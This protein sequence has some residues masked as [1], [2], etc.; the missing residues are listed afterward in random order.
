LRTKERFLG[1]FGKSPHFLF[2]GH[3]NIIKTQVSSTPK[4]FARA[5]SE[6]SIVLLRKTSGF[7]NCFSN[8]EEVR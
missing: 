6:I 4:R 2:P 3:E 8:Y 5:P 1:V 7:A